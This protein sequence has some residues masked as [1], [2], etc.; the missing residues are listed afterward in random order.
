MGS[1]A[2]FVIRSRELG[3][4]ACSFAYGIVCG[5]L[6]YFLHPPCGLSNR[7]RSIGCRS[8]GAIWAIAGFRPGLI[9][10]C[11]QGPDL[12]WRRGRLRPC[13]AQRG[14]STLSEFYGCEFTECVGAGA[15]RFIS[16]VIFCLWREGS[17]APMTQ[18]SLL[19]QWDTLNPKLFGVQGSRPLPGIPKGQRLFGRQRQKITALLKL[20][21]ARKI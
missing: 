17:A 12:T 9:P 14:A 16:P 5:Y 13:P 8:Q 6:R 11:T 21:S 7:R 2:E 18:Y 20:D 10:A 15:D 4:A 3:Q 19:N 1:A